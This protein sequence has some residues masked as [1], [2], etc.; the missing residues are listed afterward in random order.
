M[1]Q[2]RLYDQKKFW[3]KDYEGMELIAVVESEPNFEN[4]LLIDGKTYKVCASSPLQKVKGLREINFVEV[5]EVEDDW[6]DEFICPY[7]KEVDQDA[8]ELQDEGETECGNC[9]STIRYVREVVVQYGVT[10]VKKNEPI[11]IS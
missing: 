6:H 10:P 1:W 5:D 11:T 3:A 2:L 7:C 8:F 4:N 9:G